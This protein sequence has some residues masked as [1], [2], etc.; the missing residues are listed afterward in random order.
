M[1]NI[2]IGVLIAGAAGT[3]LFAHFLPLAL[4]EAGGAEPMTLAQA[5][6]AAEA[7]P[8]LVE[9]TDVQAH[10]ESEVQRGRKSG[11]TLV[12]AHFTI[13]LSLVIGS[14]WKEDFHPALLVIATIWN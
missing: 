13:Q 14:S 6:A 12:L 10:C 3:G 1:K 7:G 5:L 9:L 8:V 11:E 2:I 4:R